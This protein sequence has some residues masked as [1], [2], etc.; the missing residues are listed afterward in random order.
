[1]Q[2]QPTEKMCLEQ[3][4]KEIDRGINQ[5]RLTELS[6]EEHG[7]TRK[8]IERQIKCQ[9]WLESWMFMNRCYTKW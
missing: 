6:T 9:K 7:V 2:L 5:M 4:Q 3:Q 1:M 8:Q